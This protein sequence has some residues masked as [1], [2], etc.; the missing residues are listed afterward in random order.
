MAFDFALFSFNSVKTQSIIYVFSYLKIAKIKKRTWSELPV[1]Q[2]KNR[3]KQ[4]IYLCFAKCPII[5]HI[6]L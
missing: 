2:N 6:I 3:S 5:G 4:S 1:Y